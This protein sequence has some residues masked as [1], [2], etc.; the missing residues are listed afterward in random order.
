MKLTRRG[1]LASVAG[2]AAAG[3]AGVPSLTSPVV[4]VAYEPCPNVFTSE[5]FGLSFEITEEAIDDRFAA[6]ARSLATS[7]RR[8]SERIAAD[9]FG[10]MP[11]E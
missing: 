11:S 10:K 8:V 5:E 6:A 4:P 7:Q 2:V 9:V 3:V 1:F